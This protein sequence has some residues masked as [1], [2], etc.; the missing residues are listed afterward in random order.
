MGNTTKNKSLKER[1]ELVHSIFAT[2]AIA[3]VGIISIGYFD[4]RP[5]Y[6]RFYE[7]GTTAISIIVSA[8]VG[9]L[10]LLALWHSINLS[11]A[12][13]DERTN[14][15]R[16]LIMHEIDKNLAPIM[17]LFDSVFDDHS[18]AVGPG[19]HS[20]NL[21]MESLE[22]INSVQLN[23]PDELAFTQLLTGLPS[24]F[25]PEQVKAILGI[26]GVL[27]GLSEQIS[28]FQTQYQANGNFYD[29]VQVS[30]ASIQTLRSYRKLLP[31]LSVPDAHR[32][33]LT[34]APPQ[35]AP[36]GLRRV[37]AVLVRKSPF[38]PQTAI[39]LN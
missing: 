18:N 5:G 32:T 20:T 8:W 27:L 30:E 1:W 23:D 21:M 28:V 37:R 6:T 33:N 13:R 39:N 17:S 3:I 34:P 29:P 35:P 14:G 25:N 15:T 12:A 2:S 22:R 26:N 31:N 24:S 10:T 16:L 36:E 7:G 38:S 19:P 11:R 4:S 9:V